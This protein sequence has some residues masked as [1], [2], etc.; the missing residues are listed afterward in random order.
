[1]LYIRLFHIINLKTYN[2]NF[3]ILKLNCPWNRNTALLKDGQTV[4]QMH[5]KLVVNNW[6][7]FCFSA[8]VFNANTNTLKYMD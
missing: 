8:F 6:F 1:M 3:K 5:F 4:M 2:I 7:A